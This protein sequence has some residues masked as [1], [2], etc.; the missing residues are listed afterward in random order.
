MVTRLLSPAKINLHLCVGP[1]TGKLHRIVSLMHTIAFF[2]ELTVEKSRF[3][4]LTCN[5]KEVPTDDNN[6]VTKA[7]RIFSEYYLDGKMPAFKIHINKKVPSRAGLGGGSSNAAVIIKYLLR[8]YGKDPGPGFIKSLGPECGYDVPF[9]FS[10]GLSLVKS[11]GEEVIPLGFGLCFDCLIIKPKTGLQTAAV[12][13]QY[14][15]ITQCFPDPEIE[16]RNIRDF[17]SGKKSLTYHETLGIL[18]ND[19]QCSAFSIS[20]TLNEIFRSIPE[21]FRKGC[22]LSGSGSSIFVL[23]SDKDVQKVQTI[24]DSLPRSIIEKTVLTKLIS[25]VKIE[26]TS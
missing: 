5:K 10:S 14:D 11:F 1:R 7:V 21:Y 3:Y 19:L 16:E 25:M 26:T 15:E 9:F 24:I 23:L 6:L 4:S 13:Q 8:M 22:L 18:H 20:E 12:Y 2:D 17:M